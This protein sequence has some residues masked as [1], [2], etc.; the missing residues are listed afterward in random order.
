M[1]KYTDKTHPQ[2]VPGTFSIYSSAV[3]RHFRRQEADR[4]LLMGGES[5]IDDNAF[6]DTDPN[7]NY[8]YNQKAS[9]KQ[10]P[11]LKTRYGVIL[12]PQPTNSPNDPL[13]W[14]VLRKSIQFILLLLFTGLGAALTNNSNSPSGYINAETGISYDTLNYS[15]GVL[16]VGIA[17]STWLYS[18]FDS[19][20][21]RK[22]VIITGILFYIA[23]TVWYARLQNSGDIYGSQLL[24][25]LGAGASEAHVQL[26]LASIFFRHQLGAVITIYNLAYVL[27][28]YLGP[29]SAKMETNTHDFRWVGWYGAIASLG[30]L[31]L[32]IFFLE[33]TAF[34]YSRFKIRYDDVSLNLSLM[35]YGIISQSEN[36]AALTLG[37]YDQPFSY[38]RRLA[39]FRLIQ[40]PRFR[41]WKGFTSHYFKLLTLPVRCIWFPPVLYGGLLCGLQN[42][43]MTFYLTTEDNNLYVAPFN[44]SSDTVA[45][46]N[47]PCIIGAVVGSLYAGS[48][49]DYFVLWLARKRGGVVE[50]EYRLAFSFLSGTIGGVGLLMFGFGIAR[51]LDWRVYYVGLGFIAYMFSSALNL[52]MLYVLDTYR[53]LIL[54]TLVGVAVI[55]NMIGCVFTFV[56][57]PWLN[58]AGTESTYIVLSVIAIFFMYFS[59]VL[60]IWGKRM[61]VYTKREYIKLVEI[62]ESY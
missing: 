48:I 11:N 28:S 4:Y 60:M 36:T 62:K 1:D 15:S 21:G 39:P 40:D 43:F 52:A 30:L 22:S 10:I 9:L 41:T 49:T 18:P 33:E 34:D 50:S 61:R 46:M 27:G 2:F 57:S 5:T 20:I 55:N 56:C 59:A 44:A 14:S 17:V 37:Y 31:I 24:L 16:F 51:D 3:I 19:L 32:V 45:I 42:S 13:N 54:E 38:F 7:F 53:E 12:W 47:V 25:G 6:R 58:A 35:Q 26:C 8:R 29:L 23:G